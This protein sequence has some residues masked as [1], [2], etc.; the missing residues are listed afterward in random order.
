M[1]MTYEQFWEQSPFLTVAY[2]KAYRLKREADN[3]QAW[4]Q[5]I[6]V[7]DAFAVCLANIFAKR[8]SRKQTYIEKPIDIFP[9][10]EREKKRREEVENTKMQAAMEAMA[11]EQRLKKKS[12][13]D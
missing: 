13:G 6:Y 3:E 1:G 10:D 5:G 12:K 9:L 2:R 4:L 8:G 7:F 11:R